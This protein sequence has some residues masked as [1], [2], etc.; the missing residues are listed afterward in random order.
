LPLGLVAAM[1]GLAIPFVR[2][3]VMGAHALPVLT[4][5]ELIRSQARLDESALA[6]AQTEAWQK[7]RTGTIIGCALAEAVCLM[8]FAL[9]F[10]AQQPFFIVP[11]A[12]W[13][14][15]LLALQFPF[16]GGVRWLMSPAA[17]ATLHYR[18]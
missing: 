6:Q 16:E 3:H 14:V 9:A 15:L 7:Y 12:I 11:F 10:T 4:R 18:R 13:A 8:G 17:Q 5:S 2:S 1:F